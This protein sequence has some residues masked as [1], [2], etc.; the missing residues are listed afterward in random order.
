MFGPI[1]FDDNLE[2]KHVR[3]GKVILTGKN[4]SKEFNGNVV[5]EDVSIECAQGSAIALVGENGA[6]KSTLMNIISG[7]LSPSAGTIELDGQKIVFRDPIAAREK[8][9]AFAHQE[10][11]LM[12]ELTVGENIML[13]R[14]P[15][16][17]IFIDQKK[18]HAQAKEVLD[19][20]GY[21]INVNTMV[22]DLS[23]AECQITEIAKAWSS[24]P[25]ILILD[26]PT[27]SLNQKESHVLFDFIHRIVE[28][29]V[30]VIMISH[31]MDDIYQSCNEVIVLKDGRFV[32]HAPIEETTEEMLISKMVGRDFKN[33]YPKRREERAEK[34]KVSIKNGSVGDRVRGVSIDVPEG[35]VVGIGGLEGQGQRELSRALFG[36]AHFTGG[37]YLIDGKKVK[38]HSPA[39]AIKNKIAYVPEDRKTEGLCLSLS[40]QENILSMIWKRNSR[41]GFINKNAGDKETEEGI[42]RLNI[43]VGHPKMKVSNLSGGNQ[44]KIVFS[45][46]IKTEP[47]ILYLNE[48]T[49]GVDVQS[50]LEIYELIRS[51]T[52][53]GVSVVIFTSDMLELIG[54]SDEIY[55]MYEGRISGYITGKE[56]TEERIMQFSAKNSDEK[57]GSENR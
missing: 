48:P 5:L 36:L 38:I 44:Q 39:D 34:I 30:A 33:V 19:E 20:I 16:K 45:K 11:S 28:K 15:K 31:R 56:A 21:D 12:E 43:K 49:R 47:E 25:R 6:G 41:F 2:G 55:I 17:G 13:G 18:L 42:S 40:V 4:L 35:T 7:A 3:K 52:H 51:L 24:G 1:L 9:I 14:E 29:G 53:R 54:L 27:S 10:L 37:D 50:K 32:F 23:P 57:E 22:C 8:G 46:W 26:E